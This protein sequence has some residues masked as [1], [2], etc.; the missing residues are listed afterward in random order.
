MKVLSF[1]TRKK[2][3]IVVLSSMFLITHL[4]AIESRADY[5]KTI[6]D[7]PSSPYKTNDTKQ[8]HNI[9]IKWK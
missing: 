5:M 7:N 3:I 4:L 6:L 9:T 1:L 8:V 2:A